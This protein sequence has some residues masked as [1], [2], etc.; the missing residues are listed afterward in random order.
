MPRVIAILGPTASGKTKYAIEIA[1]AFNGEIVSCDSMQLYKFMDIG[2]AKPTLKE[3]MEVRHHLIDFVDP[4][5]EFSVA[6][7]QKYAF[8]AIDKIIEAGKTPII[9]GGTGLYLNS[10]VYNMDFSD[11]DKNSKLREELFKEANEFGNEYIHDKLKS[12]SKETAE[13]IHPN[14]LKKVIRAIEI[15]KSGN[16]LDAFDSL[17]DKNEKYEF[18]LIGL[19]RDRE[20]LYNRINKRVDLLVEE[21]LFEEVKRLMDMGLT[22][23]DI[24][25]KGIGYKEV[26]MYHN[27]E[28]SK[29]DAVELIKKNTRHYAKRQ[30]TWF[31]RYEDIHWVDISTYKDDNE[32]I[33]E[34]ITWLKK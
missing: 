2:S 15:L 30:M 19:N 4:R 12:L 1:K 27:G 17:K 3:Q 34:L 16:S 25:M 33:G 11:T 8:E 26:I 23:G 6:E 20:E 29:N 9:S 24:S 22:E 13:R 10:L 18:V 31:R 32:A 5:E 7:Y 14:N 28:I 21:G